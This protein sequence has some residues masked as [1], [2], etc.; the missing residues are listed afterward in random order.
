MTSKNYGLAAASIGLLLSMVLLLLPAGQHA[1]HAFAANLD[2]TATPTVDKGK[3]P[4][5]GSS[6]TFTD[7]STSLQDTA[8]VR[9]ADTANNIVGEELTMPAGS[10]FVSQHDLIFMPI[11]P[12]ASSSRTYCTWGNSSTFPCSSSTNSDHVVQCAIGL[13]QNGGASDITA[14]LAG[15]TDQD[16]YPQDELDEGQNSTNHI[17]VIN[18]AVLHNGMESLIS[19]SGGSTIWNLQV[20][21]RTQRR[22]RALSIQETSGSLPLLNQYWN[23]VNTLRNYYTLARKEMRWSLMMNEKLLTNLAT[24]SPTLRLPQI[25]GYVFGGVSGMSSNFARQY[26]GIIL[27]QRDISALFNQILN[28]QEGSPIELTPR[29]TSPAPTP[30]P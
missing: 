27:T 26:L 22:L 19:N 14:S 5:V 21:D 8:T 25:L 16:L 4:V 12:G 28:Q 23:L 13:D 17:G 15:Q 29:S 18:A 11:D 2:V 9:C 30:T 3:G 24:A 7:P 6:I 1:P 10:G 20:W